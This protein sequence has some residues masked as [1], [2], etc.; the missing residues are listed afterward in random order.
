[1]Y[2]YPESDIGLHKTILDTILTNKLTKSRILI[3]KRYLKQ[4][5]IWLMLE[6][7]LI[8]YFLSDMD[9][10]CECLKYLKSLYLSENNFNN[11]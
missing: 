5:S 6:I 10:K 9:N 4:T 3:A 7:N 2:V 1:M 8:T 11:I